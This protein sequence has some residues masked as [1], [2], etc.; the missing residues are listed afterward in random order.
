MGVVTWLFVGAVV[1]LLW[2]YSRWCH[3][4]WSSRGIV[5]PP[6]LPIF[7]HAQ[8]FFGSQ[9]W[10]YVDKF[11]RKYRDHKVWGLYEFLTPVLFV[12]DP[13]LL[14]HFMVKDFDHFVDRRSFGD[15]PGSLLSAMV[16]NKH[17]EEWKDL[18]GLMSP[19][20]SSGKMRGMFHLICEKAD[21]L[22]SFCLKKGVNNRPVD[23]KDMFGRFTMDTIASCAFGIECNSFSDTKPIFS[24]KAKAFFTFQG[25]R[26]L[27]L[28]LMLMKP[29]LFNALGLKADTPEV[30]FFAKICKENTAVREKGQKKR[31]DFLDLLLEARDAEE[32]LHPGKKVFADNTVVAQSVLFLMAG[33]DTTATTLA[34]AGRIM[35]THPEHQ[36]RL[37]HEMQELVKEHGSITYQG[38]MEAKFLDAFL[39]ETLRLYPPGTIGDRKCTKEYKVPGT[40]LVLKPGD[41]I[42]FSIWSLHHDPEYWPDPEEFKPERFLPE[43]RDQIKSFTHMPF[44]MGPRN[45]LAMRF[46]LMEAKVALAHLILAVDLKL[47]PG[48]EEMTFENSP[49]LLRPSGGVTMLLTPLKED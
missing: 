49:I 8:Q 30:E 4:Y 47:A 6:A 19:T 11:Y 37:R 43:N 22:V 36:Q 10:L 31:G 26:M 28:G 40:D 20:F 14:K 7:G 42:N 48:N 13:D 3:S 46:A 17:G 16:T 39:M 2:V 34:F 45:C 32:R 23:M 21:C 9:R 38:V 25:V 29:K 1:L 24:E 44:G 41:M 15:Q 12:S 18:R 27:R 5:S 33:Y 35:A